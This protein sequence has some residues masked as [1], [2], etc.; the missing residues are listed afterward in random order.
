MRWELWDG[1]LHLLARKIQSLQ[2]MGW[3]TTP[4]GEENPVPMGN[5]MGL[6]AIW[7]GESLAYAFT[8]RAWGN[9]MELYTFWRGESLA[10]AF[11]ARA[12]DKDLDY[13]FVLLKYMSVP[14]LTQCPPRLRWRKTQANF[15]MHQKSRFAKSLQHKAT[16]MEDELRYTNAVIPDVQQPAQLTPATPQQHESPNQQPTPEVKLA[17][18]RLGIGDQQSAES[19]PQ[20]TLE[21][22]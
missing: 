20:Q 11:T 19:S 22:S 5:G 15:R 6:Y 2:A 1:T 4:F 16:L 17:V 18:R 9:G 12:L 7:Q 14:L 10:Y 21:C 13:A 8:E 3:D